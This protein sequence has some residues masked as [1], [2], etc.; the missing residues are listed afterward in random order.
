MSK[1]FSAEEKLAL[2]KRVLSGEKLT[3]VSKEAGISRTILYRWLQAFK[4]ADRNDDLRGLQPKNIS[5]EAHWRTLKQT[6]KQRIIKTALQHP[7]M[8]PQPT[9]CATRCNV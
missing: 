8:T 2:I 6:I 3:R 5:G 1:Q 7:E 4:Q 9:G